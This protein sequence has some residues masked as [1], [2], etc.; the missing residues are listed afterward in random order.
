MSKRT[1]EY[2]KIAE[3]LG[4]LYALESAPEPPYTARTDREPAPKPALPMLGAA[5]FTFADPTFGSRMLRV[6]DGVSVPGR[7]WT[8]PSSTLT[9]AWSADSKAFYI[10]GAGGPQL[11]RFNHDTFACEAVI[12]PYSQCEPCFSRH[13]PTILYGAGGPSA[14]VIKRYDVVTHAETVLLDL[15]TLGY[16]LVEPRTYVGGIYAGGSP[17]KIVVFYGGQSQG[18]HYLVTVMQPDGTVIETI[19]TQKLGFLL[20]SSGCDLSGRFV[21]LYP[22]NAKPAP[23]YVWDLEAHT[24]TAETVAATGHG[25]LGF[26][27]QTNMDVSSGPNDSAQWQRRSLL[28]LDHPVNL[29]PDVLRPASGG[30]VDH[31]SWNNAKAD[32]QVPVLSSVF[33]NRAG[34][35]HRAWDDEIIAVSTDGSG[36]VYRFAHHRHDVNEPRWSQPIAHVSPDGKYAIFTSNWEKT[37]GLET[38]EGG[39]RNDVLLVALG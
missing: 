25:A 11:V 26:G 7:S 32:T 30:L 18:G 23:A 22:N 29:I 1:D 3:A 21:T 38:T 35:P 15:D 27:V 19:D 2:D 33:R 31:Q 28:D 8:V 5:G 20:H 6:T 39:H 9:A 4:V 13:D 24:V 12:T 36:T 17:E 37:L 16:P 14:R 10:W 34:D